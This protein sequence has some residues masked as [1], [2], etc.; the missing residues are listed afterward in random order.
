MIDSIG[1]SGKVNNMLST[2]NIAPINRRNLQD[3]ERR[4]GRFVECVAKQSKE[5]AAREAFDS[6][7]M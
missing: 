3:M 6:E 1:G 5:T 2:L 4:A 7:M